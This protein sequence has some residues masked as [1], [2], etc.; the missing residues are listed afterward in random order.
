MKYCPVAVVMLSRVRF[1]LAACGREKSRPLVCSHF[2]GRK[3]QAG[4]QLNA[5]HFKWGFTHIFGIC[6]Q[7]RYGDV[8]SA[9]PR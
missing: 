4:A 2:M 8:A 6:G 1:V 9:K 3:T 7:F 5:N